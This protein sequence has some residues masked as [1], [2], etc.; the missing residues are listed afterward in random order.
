MRG[1]VRH[2]LMINEMK[3][4]GNRCMKKNDFSGAIVAYSTALGKGTWV[5]QAIELVE[6]EKGRKNAANIERE[7]FEAEVE[8]LGLEQVHHK[9]HHH[10]SNSAYANFVCIAFTRLLRTEKLGW[11]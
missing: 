2:E 10:S 5:E 11:D 6:A 8:K 7:K 3:E 4:R 9:P 1:P